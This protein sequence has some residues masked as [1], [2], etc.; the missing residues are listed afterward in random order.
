MDISTIVCKHQ[1]YGCILSKDTFNET[2]VNE[3]ENETKTI[4]EA[5]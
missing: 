1:T 5:N 3:E 2:N 4:V